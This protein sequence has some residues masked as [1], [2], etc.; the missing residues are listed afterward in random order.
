MKKLN[1]RLTASLVSFVVSLIFLV[2]ISYSKVCIFFACLFM[3]FCLVL[4]TLYRHEQ[5]QKTLQATEED[6][7][8]NPAE[9]DEIEEIEKLKKKLTKKNRRIDFAF[10]ICAFLLLV[11]GVL[12][13][14]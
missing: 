13:L 11:A 6:L 2:C 8:E 4:F 14:I 5:F 1:L 3:A 10:Y 7:N 9:D 12:A